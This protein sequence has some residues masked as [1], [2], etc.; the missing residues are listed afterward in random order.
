MRPGDI[1]GYTSGNYDSMKLW[2]AKEL[3][4]PSSTPNYQ[5]R[6]ISMRLVA[7]CAGLYVIG[8]STIGTAGP[9]LTQQAGTPSKIHYT[10]CPPATLRR[11]PATA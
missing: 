3:P 2:S 4:L 9:R 6:T 10:H 5:S 8:K 11:W 7:L 1:R